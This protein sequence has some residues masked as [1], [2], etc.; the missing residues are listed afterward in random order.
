MYIIDEVLAA[1]AVARR[2][3][4]LPPRSDGCG[5]DCAKHLAVDDMHEGVFEADQ[6]LTDML[7][8]PLWS[9][10][11][12][13]DRDVLHRIAAND[14]PM[15]V[16]ALASALGKSTSY[17][18]TYRRRLLRAGAITTPDRGML[19]VRD[20]AMRRWLT[21]LRPIPDLDH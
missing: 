4:H 12:P 16:A 10:L 9:T 5:V 8:M 2:V 1:R 6:A 17:I 20:P 7:L 3:R 18:N 21:D 19:D 14:G 15:H 13:T 11:S